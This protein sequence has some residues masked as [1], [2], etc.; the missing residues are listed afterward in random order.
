MEPRKSCPDRQFL[1]E[2]IRYARMR[3]FEHRS[4]IESIPVRD[5]RQ[6]V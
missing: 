5:D 1:D 3:V 4:G 2:D 6:G